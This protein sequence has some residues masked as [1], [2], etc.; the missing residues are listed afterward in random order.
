MGPEVEYA[1]NARLTELLRSVV[2]PGDF[3]THGRLFLLMPTVN[4]ESVGLLSFPVP[5]FQ[6]RALTEAAERAPYGK[7]SETVVDTSVR[8]CWQI[9][10]ARL[11][12]GGHAWDDT[13]ATILDAAAEG[14]GFRGGDLEARLYKLLVYPVGGFFAP[15]RDTE[16]VDRMVATLTISL[17]TAGAG[18]ELVV[19]HGDREEVVDMN[20]A[21]PSELAFAA[22][23]ADC[24]HE[25]RPVREGHR[26]SLV[27]NLC[28][29]PGDTETPRH[30]SN[31]SAEAEA[32]ARHL[33]DWFD[34]GHGKLVWLLEHDYT[35]AGLSFDT[36]K[37]ADKAVARVLAGAAAPAECALHAAVVHIE[38][39]GNAMYSD[40]DYVM[41]WHWRESDI[42]AM[43]I[44]DLYDSRHWLDSWI[45][46]DGS[47]PPFDEIPLLPEELLPT[48][49][50]D[51]AAPDERRVH[52]ASGN[53]G[54]DLE[55]SYRRA[56]M[57]IWPRSNTL[58]VIAGAGIRAAVDWV[59]G[60]FGVTPRER[61]EE[62]SA[63][64]IGTWRHDPREREEDATASRVR[65]L[66]LL[67]VIGNAGLALQFL[68]EVAL[69]HY[70]GGE[71]ADL[72][73]ALEMVGE[74]AAGEYLPDFV[75]AHF[76]D[77]PEQTMALLRL[78]DEATSV[79][80]RSALGASVAQAVAALP[81]ALNA[82]RPAKDWRALSRRT[83]ISAAC[84]C[85][86]FALAW[87]CN[88]I[89]D[90][91]AAAALLADHPQRVTPDRM[92][93]AVLEGLRGEVGLEE[94]EA[95]VTLWRHA[96][97]FLL[98]RSATPPEAPSD[99]TTAANVSCPCQHCVKLRAFCED[100][101]VRV[102][103]YPL[104]KELRKH[105]HRII[106]EHR[107]DLSHETERRGRP[108]TLVCTKNRASYKRRL[109]EYAEDIAHMNSLVASGPCGR[110][111]DL[112]RAQMAALRDAT[113]AGDG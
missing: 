39:T 72:L 86:L 36:L 58:D 75:A 70:G 17:P 69:S 104:R 71:N 79:L 13:F 22:F 106:D 37:N 55:R 46:A 78:A 60:Q 28:V 100:P 82:E 81:D 103:R 51:G 33:V 14:L 61:I 1:T 98:K 76:A 42:E 84:L 53:E 24:S 96:A 10:A 102:A 108:F 59:A 27:Y 29:L 4:V 44:G 90:A 3:C 6:I 41:S 5:D 40:D 99:W 105:L 93:P 11:R 67:R 111:A 101:V 57:V 89:D 20:A 77:V 97:A 87:R 64:L 23:Y 49:A 19:R 43:E 47:C 95:Y 15:H 66:D 113:R 45:G 25:T 35:A 107:L 83:S 8:D 88:S 91:L 63:R 74:D 73:A 94:T 112:C 32:V 21:E 18:G 62:L 30:A 68:R 65:M 50:L 56:A 110:Q 92:V 80:T 109:A 52:E 9:D 34:G 2:R 31:Y 48:G 16:K 54:V 26:L 12:I 85:D 7:G 38:E